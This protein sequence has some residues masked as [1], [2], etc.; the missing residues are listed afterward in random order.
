MGL[1][2]GMI[3]PTLSATSLSVVARERIGYAASLYNMMRNTGAAIGIAYMTTMLVDHEQI[4]QSRL[5][6]HL[7]VFDAW[8]L[9]ESAPRM[10]GAP[11]FQYLPQMISGQHQSFGMLYNAIQAQAAI[12]SFNDIYRI[13]AVVMALM[14]PGFLVLRKA[15]RV[16]RPRRHTL[17]EDA[18]VGQLRER[19]LKNAQCVLVEQHQ[20]DPFDRREPLQWHR[21]A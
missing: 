1:G 8:K 7:S 18:L 14:V 11:S 15:Q 13:L 9:S 4:H 21:S 12:L 20:L 6:E 3:F 5:A 19:I 2:M 10:P 17:G 16:S